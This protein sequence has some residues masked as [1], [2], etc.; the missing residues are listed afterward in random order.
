M[1]IEDIRYH[2]HSQEKQTFNL[3]YDL[4][5]IKALPVLFIPKTDYSRKEYEQKFKQRS[6]LVFT[7]NLENDNLKAEKAFVY[8][9]TFSLLTYICG[10]PVVSMLKYY[11]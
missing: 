2:Y 9:F 8:R 3:G 11:F 10:S 6:L 7:Y 5:D 1:K 4:E